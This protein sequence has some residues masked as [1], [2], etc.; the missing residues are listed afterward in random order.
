MS[1]NDLTLRLHVIAIL[2]CMTPWLEIIFLLNF[3][4]V[5]VLTSS[6]SHPVVWFSPLR[7][8]QL[9]LSLVFWKFN[10]YI[11]W[12]VS[13]F[14]KCVGHRW[15]IQSRNSYSS[16]LAKCL[17]VYFFDNFFSKSSLFSP[18][19]QLLIKYRSSRIAIF[20]LFLCL[21][22]LL[23]ERITGLWN[24]FSHHIFFFPCFHWKLSSYFVFI[25]IVFILL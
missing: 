22:I 15:T 24:I 6:Y 14:I 23:Y 25:F 11:L 21:F 5:A 8:F 3:E 9:T 12:V 10:Y 18:L 1:E 16:I 19:E 13:F 17:A 7:N 4:G 2:V 20:L